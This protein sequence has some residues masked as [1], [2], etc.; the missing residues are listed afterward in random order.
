MKKRF[1][2]TALMLG[3]TFSM[4]WASLKVEWLDGSELTKAIDQIGRIE[5]E[6]DNMNLV[7]LDGNLLSSSKIAEVRKISFVDGVESSVFTPNSGVEVSVF[8]NPTSDVLNIRG[9]EEDETVRLFSP[10]GTLLKSSQG[11]E[12]N[13]EDLAAGIYLL[14]VRTQIYKVV[15]Q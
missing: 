9:I 7:D 1:I 2:S 12:L 3:L 6:G 10:T 11:A 5:F 15:K 13:M 8:P 14:Q 4:S